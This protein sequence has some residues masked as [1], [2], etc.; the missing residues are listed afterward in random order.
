[1]AP[2]LTPIERCAEVAGLAPHEIMLG[3]SPSKRHGQMLAKYRRAR[4]SMAVARVKI[5]ADL[6]AAILRGARCEAADLLIVLRRLLAL[7]PGARGDRAIWPE[8]R[9]RGAPRTRSRWRAPAAAASHLSVRAAE[10]VVL[11][12]CDFVV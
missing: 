2:R 4:R 12:H 8:R 1:M 10:V 9:P 7:G 6:R 3:V 5:V 11:R